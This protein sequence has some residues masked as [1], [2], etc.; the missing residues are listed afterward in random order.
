MSIRLSKLLLVFSLVLGTSFILS[1]G[2]LAFTLESVKIDSPKYDT[3]I[4][5]KDLVADVLPPPMFVIEAYSLSME[6]ALHP[7][8]T[9]ENVARIKSLKHDFD[10]RIAYWRTVELPPA[11]RKTVFDRVLPASQA[12]WAEMDEGMIPALTSGKSNTVVDRTAKLQQ[13]YRAQKEAVEQ[14]VEQANAFLELSQSEAHDYTL[15]NSRIAYGLAATALVI[16]VGGLYL[17]FRRAIAPT[18]AMTGFMTRLAEGADD[19]PVPFADRGDEVGEM[20]RAVEVFRANGVANKRLQLEA[21]ASQARAQA[22]RA[23][24][25]RSAEADAQ[26]RLQN[27]TAGLA[28]GLRKLAAGDLTVRLNET[29]SQEFEALRHDFNLSVE[30]LGD[31][32]S[33]VSDITRSMDSG[34]REIAEG[35]DALS[36]RT[37]QQAA[38]LEETA[39]ALDQ[40][41]TNVSMSAKRTESARRLSGQANQSASH[42]EEVVASAVKAMQRIEHSSRQ[43]SNIIT[44][45][46]EIA[47]QTNLLA[48]NAGVEAARAGDAGKGFAVVAQEVRELAQRSARAAKE[49]KTLILT[50]STQVESGV[51]LVRESG[52]A[53]QTIKCRIIDINTHVGEIAASALEQASALAQVNS[54]VNNMDQTTQ[55]NAAMVEETTAAAIVMGARRPGCAIWSALSDLPPGR[56]T[57]LATR[58]ATH[59]Q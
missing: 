19:V 53:L 12:F 44:V 3:I 5:G 33:R 59:S 32:L 56:K 38:S 30:Q 13:V 57:Q 41:T 47:F 1:L 6:S 22:D 8:L 46:D 27:A 14:L 58:Q 4:A 17:F 34:T 55:Q 2:F 24:L 50:S 23:E 21:K 52:E 15:V 54:A 26:L 28:A 7:E 45:I 36:R 11:I 43:I 16:L 42:S 51:A 48:L 49:I 10:S 39:A 20:A 18:V 35:A 31:A 29:F 25:Q 37:E 40:I 9:T